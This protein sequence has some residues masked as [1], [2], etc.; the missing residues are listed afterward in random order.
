MSKQRAFLALPERAV[1]YN[2]WLGFKNYEIR[3]LFETVPYQEAAQIKPGDTLW[4][5]ME[6][7]SGRVYGYDRVSVVSISESERWFDLTIE[8]PC[9]SGARIPKEQCW[10][11]VHRCRDEARLVEI[12]E[13]SPLAIETG[14]VGTI[15]EAS[16][17][18]LKSIGVIVPSVES[19]R[20]G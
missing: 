11:K 5:D 3:D 14:T 13:T 15:S 17:A 4:I 16:K 7:L 18:Y 1:H 8:G 12:I 6:L 10:H 19:D 9:L 20:L 2:F